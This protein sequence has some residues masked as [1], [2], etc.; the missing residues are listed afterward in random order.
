MKT[1]VLALAAAAALG[2][3]A[4]AQAANGAPRGVAIEKVGLKNQ[5]FSSRHRYWHRH[6][7]HCDTFW[8]HGRRITV[9][10]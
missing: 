1:I 2:L 6:H 3:A 4:P 9:C 10:R 7:R 5:D 8:R